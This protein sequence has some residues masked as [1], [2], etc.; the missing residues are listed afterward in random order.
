MSDAA[1]APALLAVG[2]FG[3]GVVEGVVEQDTSWA[4]AIAVPWVV[5]TAAGTWRRR[6]EPALR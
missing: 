5:G 4:L 6:R 2:L 3:L 1:A